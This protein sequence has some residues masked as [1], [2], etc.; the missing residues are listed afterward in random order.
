MVGASVAERPE[1]EG[2]DE[3]RAH[4]HHHGLIPPQLRRA[5][6]ANRGACVICG[7]PVVVVL[8]NHASDA[9]S[10]AVRV[11]VGPGRRLRYT[12]VP[13]AVIHQSCARRALGMGVRP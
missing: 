6:E 9:A 1:R 3:L 13:G 2:S 4:P 8:S 11:Y 10:L 5:A 12:V 7:E